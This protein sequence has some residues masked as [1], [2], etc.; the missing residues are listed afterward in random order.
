[1]NKYI[2][3]IIFFV[4]V[5]G[6]TSCS[7]N[8]SLESEPSQASATCETVNVTGDDEN[9]ET[10]RSEI[11]TKVIESLNVSEGDEMVNSVSSYKTTN[12]SIRSIRCKFPSLS[13]A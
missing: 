9:T 10:L 13:A 6:F 8:S 4:T 7:D 12:V 11:T 2:L 3:L 1:M 5:F